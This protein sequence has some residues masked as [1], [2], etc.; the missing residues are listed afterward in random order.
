[1]AKAA[2]GAVDPAT[3][4]KMWSCAGCMSCSERCPSS[5]GPAELIV[6]LREVASSL[7]NRPCHIDDE[8]KLYHRTGLC[9]PCTGLTKKM[10]RDLGLEE[11]DLPEDTVREVRDI[12]SRT[13]LRGV[14]NE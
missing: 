13:R 8:A 14:L 6:L 1:M 10:R 12:V 11:A 4:S 7:G 9:F 2:L 3:E 5:A